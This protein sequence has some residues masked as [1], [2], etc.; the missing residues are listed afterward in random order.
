MNFL[1]L[2]CIPFRNLYSADHFLLPK[3]YET[4]CV[5]EFFV[6][7]GSKSS[8]THTVSE[9]RIGTVLEIK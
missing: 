5:S 2:K 4:V 9:V 6:G 8:D 7:W 3:R 1:V